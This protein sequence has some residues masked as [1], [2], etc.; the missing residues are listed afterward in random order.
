MDGKLKVRRDYTVP[1]WLEICYFSFKTRI[2][3]EG[4]FGQIL[5]LGESTSSGEALI[6]QTAA[7]PLQIYAAANP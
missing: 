7:E 5:G 3:G 1:Q 4:L 6:L 2:K